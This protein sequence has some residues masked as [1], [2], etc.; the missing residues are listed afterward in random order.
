M[1]MTLISIGSSM[2]LVVSTFLWAP[3]PG[4]VAGGIAVATGMPAYYM[5]TRKNQSKSA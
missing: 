5:W 2:I 4:L 3:I 1:V